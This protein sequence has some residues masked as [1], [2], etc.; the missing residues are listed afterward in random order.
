MVTIEVA[1]Q[2][3]AL[4]PQKAALLPDSHTLLIADAHIGIRQSGVPLLKIADLERDADL[5][6]HARGVA[7]KLLRDTPQAAEAHLKR[8][9]RRAEDYVKV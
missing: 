9:L 7:E 6:E 5:L 4:L 3:L 8:W 1:G 2:A